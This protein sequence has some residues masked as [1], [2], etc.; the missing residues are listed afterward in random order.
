MT[1][2]KQQA[3]DLTRW[4]EQCQRILQD[5]LAKQTEKGVP[6]NLDPL[7]LGTSFAELGQRLIADP[8]PVVQAQINAWQSFATLWQRTAEQML[9]LEGEPVVTAAS[10]DWRF[11][12]EVW[13]QSPVFDFIKQSYLIAAETIQS[14]VAGANGLDESTAR[15]VQFHTRQFVDALAPTNFML[16]NPQVLKET[17]D[18][19]GGNLVQG[20]N[21]LLRDLEAGQGELQVMMSNPEAFELGENLGV[22]PGKVVFQN[23]L[24]QLLQFSPATEEVYR[25]PI[26]IVPPWINKYYILDLR[27]KNSFVKW[28]T[29]QGHTVFVISWAN[30]DES[31]RE[32][33]FEHYMIEGPLKALDAIKEA[34]G[35]REVNAIGYCLG[36]TLL[37]AT[38]A[39]MA[40]KKDTR[41][42]SATFFVSLIDFTEPG[43]LG[44]FIDE[45]QIAHLESMMAEKGYL[46]GKTMATTFSMLRAND[47]IWWFVVHNYLLGKEPLEFDLLYWNSD[48]TRMPAAMHSFYL[49]KMYLENVF[50]DPGGITLDGVPID[51]GAIEIPCNF[52]SARDDHIAPWKSTYAGARRLGGPVR[53]T[54]GKSGHIA[55][56]INPPAAEKYG[57]YTS[58]E[59]SEDPEQWIVS[60]AEHPGSWW[61]DW[62][63]WLAPY[64]GEQVPKRVPGDGNLNVLEDAPGSY[65]KTRADA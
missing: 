53:F 43:D 17:L 40:A 25:R 20:L 7:S 58:E 49:R 33:T 3:P 59:L 62:S 60:A 26:L 65:A 64:A 45:G 28:L 34:T 32:K 50:K 63:S 44:A 5:F 14:T 16:S 39:Y 11:K 6:T 41:V 47:L 19:N 37:S 29:E 52:V 21:N 31:L 27:P 46:D 4:S 12:D 30:P 23:D 55:G 48:S 57:Y 38:L 18:T 56:I 36:G 42:T 1:E 2:S 51:V 15:K 61:P 24:I 22:T 54:L 9:G 8:E 13:K 35:E 10:D